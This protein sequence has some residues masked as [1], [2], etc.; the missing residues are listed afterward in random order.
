MCTQDVISV[1]DRLDG[2]PFVGVMVLLDLVNRHHVRDPFGQI[3]TRWVRYAV[4]FTLVLAV[5]LFSRR[6]DVQFIY[7]QF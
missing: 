7:F 3:T 1:P 2:L 5:V 6:N 4:Y